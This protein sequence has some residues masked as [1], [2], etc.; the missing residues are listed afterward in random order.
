MY[1]LD[2]ELQRLNHCQRATILSRETLDGYRRMTNAQ[3]LAL[4]LEMAREATPFLLMGTPDQVARRF[5]LI[6]R[7]NDERNRNMLTAIA[8][9]RSSDEGSC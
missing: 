6:R 5:E 3:R 2:G 4:T 1:N 8:R 7:Q 9:T